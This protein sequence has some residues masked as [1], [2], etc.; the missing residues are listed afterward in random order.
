MEVLA[1]ELTGAALDYVQ[2]PS[3]REWLALCW[4]R[5]CNPRVYNPWLPHGIEERLGVTYF[6]ELKPL[7][8]KV[9]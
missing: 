1:D 7:A 8:A 3:L 9:S 5:G 6:G 4:K 2:G